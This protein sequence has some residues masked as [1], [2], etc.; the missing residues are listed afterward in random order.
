MR[1]EDGRIY[2]TEFQ[3]RILS[4]VVKTREFGHW[5]PRSGVKDST[6]VPNQ[7]TQTLRRAAYAAFKDAVP[8]G[9]ELASRCGVRACIAPEHQRMRSC[10]RATRELSL[11]DLQ[12]CRRPP[13]KREPPR[14]ASLPDGWTAKEVVLALACRGSLASAAEALGRGPDSYQTLV[15]IWNGKYSDA[16]RAAAKKSRRS[17]SD[18]LSAEAAVAEASE[19][20]AGVGVLGEEEAAWLSR[21]S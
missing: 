8:A 2:T 5:L 14:A 12:M 21:V 13:M 3:K 9:V 7:G 11:P 17:T 6:A 10:G 18:G 19:R 15:E 1:V 20:A 4:S 16:L